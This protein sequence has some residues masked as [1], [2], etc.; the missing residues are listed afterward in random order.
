MGGVDGQ[1]TK[2][3]PFF[4]LVVA[5]QQQ[6]SRIQLVINIIQFRMHQQLHGLGVFLAVEVKKR[7][8]ISISVVANTGFQVLFRQ[9]QKLFYPGIFLQA[10][11][12]TN[13]VFVGKGG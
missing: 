1:G 6:V 5:N 13:D 10:Q 11:S 2:R 4:Q 9:I 12:Q 7:P 8:V 3:I